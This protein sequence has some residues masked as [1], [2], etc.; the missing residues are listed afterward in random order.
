MFVGKVIWKY[1]I[2]IQ[3]EPVEIQIPDASKCLYVAKQNND[4]CVWFEI[5]NTY[6]SRVLYYFYVIGTGHPI[7]HHLQY[8]GT[9]LFPPFVWHL[10]YQV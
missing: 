8:L 7:P 2:P 9:A 10:Y 4:L 3:D 6:S 1:V 5:P